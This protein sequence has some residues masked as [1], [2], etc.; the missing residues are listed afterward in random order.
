VSLCGD[1]L[2]ILATDRNENCDIHYENKHLFYDA[3]FVM[4]CV[5]IM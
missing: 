5:V 2:D 1:K 4:R 3:L